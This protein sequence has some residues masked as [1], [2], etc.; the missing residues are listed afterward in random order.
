MDKVIIVGAGIAGLYTA[1]ELLKKKKYSVLIIEKEKELGGRM[2]TQKVEIDKKT[3]FLEGGAGVLRDDDDTTIKLLH[4][5]D[6]PLKFWQSDSAIVYNDGNKSQ[7]R[8]FDYMKATNELCKNSENNKSFMEV[9][10]ENTTLP[11]KEKIGILIG[12]TYSELF[13]ANSK[14]VCENNDWFEF[15]YNRKANT[16]QFGK[17]KAWLELT[18]RLELEI[19]KRGGVILRNTCV[20][21]IKNSSVKTNKNQ[22]YPFDKLIVTCPYHFFKKIKTPLS[23]KGWRY[24]MDKYHEEVDYL[25]VYSYFEEPLE[26]TKKI[27]TNLSIRRVIP[28]SNQ[29]IM[30]VYTDGN[31]AKYIHKICKDDE[32]LSEYIRDELSVLLE[33]DIPKIKKNWCFFWPK[34]ISY[35][36]PSEYSVEEMVEMVRHPVGNIYF[37]GDTYSEHPGWLDGA[38]DSCEFIVKSF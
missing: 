19:Q 2:Y 30:S 1:Y 21:E 17:P 33:R 32:K 14:D 28:I 13:D 34:G 6:I 11:E 38:M 20:T 29:M 5:L 12:T 22:V 15:L 26:I 24:F 4:E 8:E 27:S 31:D 36:K 37:C 23:L 7:I 25:R 18:N 3:F 10:E 35:W 16:H 9:L